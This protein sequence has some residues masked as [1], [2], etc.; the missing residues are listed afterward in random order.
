MSWLLPS[1]FIRFSISV[2]VAVNTKMIES[3]GT[4][5]LVITFAVRVKQLMVEIIGRN[6][7]SLDRMI[8]TQWYKWVLSRLGSYVPPFAP[9]C[10]VWHKRQFSFLHWRIDGWPRYWGS[11][12]GLDSG[13]CFPDA[14][15]PLCSRQND[16]NS[17]LRFSQ[18]GICLRWILQYTD[19]SN[20]IE[21]FC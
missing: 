12:C 9:V 2:I 3:F 21:W 8:S 6:P 5:N 7:K 20:R 17:T 13:F 14:S 1:A 16:Q 10:C 19:Q 18:A 4:P 11:G 15:H